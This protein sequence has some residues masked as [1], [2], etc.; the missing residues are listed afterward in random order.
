[1]AAARLIPSPMGRGEAVVGTRD[2]DDGD[3]TALNSKKWRFASFFNRVK[4]Q[5]QEHWHP[6][7]VYR[8]RD[9]NRLGHGQASRSRGSSTP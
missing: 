9:P 2:V 8:R 5:V 1:M 7:E 4:H 3:E 6:D